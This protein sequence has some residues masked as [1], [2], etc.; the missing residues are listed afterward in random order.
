M[1][2]LVG[3]EES[4]VVRDAF[5]RRGHNAWSNDLVPARNGGPHLQMDVMQA[6]P[7]GW[8]III[9]H[10]DCTAMAVSGNRTYGRNKPDHWER[11]AQVEWTMGL[12]GL[13]KQYA[14]LGVVLENPASVIFPK[15][16]AAGAL[17]QY[18]HPWQFGHPEQK[19]TGLA[20]HNLP[21]LVETDN[22]YETMMTLPLRE[23]E[24]V[25]HMPP[26]PNRKRDRSTTYHGVAEALA[27]QYG[28]LG[29]CG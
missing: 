5:L 18:I 12:W 26:G 14:R 4:G 2:V 16:K 13:A 25:F 11:I 1:R 3:C 22:V 24:R 6:V 17:V 20:L 9:L 19:K 7:L 8:D 10:P 28:A 27:E 23:R 29:R 15:L 21:K